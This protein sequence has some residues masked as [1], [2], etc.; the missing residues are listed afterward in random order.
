MSLEIF[1]QSYCNRV[2]DS[3]ICR[4]RGGGI[5]LRQVQ[6][7]IERTGEGGRPVC[8]PPPGSDL[9]H[10]GLRGL[11]EL[12]R[13]STNQQFSILCTCKLLGEIVTL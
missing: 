5:N 13:I 12:Y 11:F 8:P 9:I 2:M 10:M 3:D 1:P 7:K 6:R 4:R